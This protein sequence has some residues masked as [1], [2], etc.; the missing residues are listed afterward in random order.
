MSPFS[1]DLLSHTEAQLDFILEMY[2]L[3]NPER[4]TFVRAGVEKS[5]TPVQEAVAWEAV[6][7]GKAHDA[8]M[9]PMMPSEATLGVL[10]QMERMSKPQMR[11]GPGA[12]GKGDA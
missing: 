11:M 2:A 9:A 5:M 4:G 3:D 6:L 12:K 7:V 8:M 10:R 1:L